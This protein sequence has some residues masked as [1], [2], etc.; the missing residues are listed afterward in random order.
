MNLIKVILCN[1]RGFKDVSVDLEN[2]TYLIGEN[3][4]GKT[5]F[6]DALKLVLRGGASSRSSSIGRSDYYTYVDVDKNEIE[7]AGS[8]SIITEFFIPKKAKYEDL[9]IQLDDVTHL[10][11]DADGFNVYMK[12]TSVYDNT[13]EENDT[14]FEFLNPNHDIMTL[15]LKPSY[16]RK[17][18]LDNFVFFYLPAI[19]DANYEFNPRSRFWGAILKRLDI[20]ENVKESVMQKVQELN[21][22]LYGNDDKFQRVTELISKISTILGH[23]NGAKV[24]I[25]SIPIE[26]LEI[27]KNTEIKYRESNNSLNYTLDRHG[28]G[29]QSLSIIFLFQAF[30]EIYLDSNYDKNVTSFLAI[31]EPEVHLH[32][33]AIKSLAKFFRDYDDQLLIT[34]HSEYIVQNASLTEIRKFLKFASQ[35]FILRIKTSYVYTGKL[36]KIEGNRLDQLE[37]VN[38]NQIDNSFIIENTLTTSQFEDL[39]KVLNEG[40]P[41]SDLNRDQVKNEILKLLSDIDIRNFNR[42]FQLVLPEII[43]SM[44]WILVEGISDRYYIKSFAGYLGIDF[45]RSSISLINF[46]SMEISIFVKVAESLKIE[47][48]ILTDHDNKYDEISKSLEKFDFD[49]LELENKLL[50][51]PEEGQ[52]VEDYLLSNGCFE[53]FIHLLL[54]NKKHKN[55]SDGKIKLF[56]DQNSDKE[57]LYLDDEFKISNKNDGTLQKIDIKNPS[58]EE[59]D[60][61]SNHLKNNKTKLS[62]L[63]YLN[64][65]EI[66]KFTDGNFEVPQLFQEIFREFCK[67]EV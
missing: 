55:Q 39:I 9:Y 66:I 18:I 15:P 47:Y 35:I 37:F 54:K 21:K 16:Y 60:L 53:L 32:P 33:H 49:I 8:F 56:Y 12:F 23:F 24:T 45:D 58:R 20:D 5:S 19:R 44:K 65:N 22:E 28:Q 6:I 43:F 41:N 3:N 50:T 36:T 38:S 1:F 34:S 59:I 17:I 13:L 25:D 30:K 7:V 64:F 11:L 31:E 62:Q 2:K 27:L 51:Y 67:S 57:L 42:Y 52:V 48:C 29:T 10:N 14:S 63:L 61:L 4:S 26:P 46:A 40:D